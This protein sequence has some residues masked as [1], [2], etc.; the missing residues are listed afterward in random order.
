MLRTKYSLFCCGARAKL[1]DS[2]MPDGG[3]DQQGEAPEGLDETMEVEPTINVLEHLHLGFVDEDVSDHA[4]EGE[5]ILELMIAA[6]LLYKNN[7]LNVF[8]L[9]QIFLEILS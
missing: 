5:R 4:D 3:Q 7:L 9:R 8:E 1:S 2:D 6:S